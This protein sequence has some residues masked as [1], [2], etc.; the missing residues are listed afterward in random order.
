V[1]D[2]L[3]A[4]SATGNFLGLFCLNS[5]GSGTYSQYGVGATVVASGTGK[6]L[7]SGAA[8]S[9]SASGTGLALLEQKTSSASS[10]T[11]TAPTP[12]KTGTFIL[13]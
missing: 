10:F 12:M 1:A 3:F 4:S 9:I 7:T 13:S 6:V 11:E 2:D 8:T 5:S